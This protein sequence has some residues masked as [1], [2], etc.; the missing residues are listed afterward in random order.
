MRRILAL[1]LALAALPAAGAHADRPRWDAKTLAIV[2][3]PGFPARVYVLDQRPRYEET[4]EEPDG[5]TVCSPE[6]E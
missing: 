6:F 4:Y 2:P 3:P 1:T 5:N